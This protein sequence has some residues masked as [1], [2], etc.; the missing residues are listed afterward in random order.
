LRGRMLAP[1]GRVFHDIC[2]YT[3]L[4]LLRHSS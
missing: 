2:I 1:L 4:Y 3:L